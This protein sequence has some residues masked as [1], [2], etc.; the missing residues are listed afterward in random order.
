MI[1]FE[2]LK[3][4]E[5]QWNPNKIICNKHVG[6]GLRLS[7]IQGPDCY[8][9]KHTYE[10]AV[11]LNNN[12]VPLNSTDEV[13]GWQRPEDIDEILIQM[14]TDPLFIHHMKEKFGK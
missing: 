2:D 10:V 12:I 3:F 7:V 11:Y 6:P 5:D 8:C 13:R 4:T 9:D 14:Q 1:Q